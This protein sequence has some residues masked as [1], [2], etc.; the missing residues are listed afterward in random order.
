MISGILRCT[1]STRGRVPITGATSGI[2][3]EAVRRFAEL[4]WEVFA[5][6]RSEARR[7]ELAASSKE[8]LVHVV[9]LDVDRADSIAACRAEV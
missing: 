4:G 1:M 5:T 9:A 7:R 3:R 8:G 2:G 6:G